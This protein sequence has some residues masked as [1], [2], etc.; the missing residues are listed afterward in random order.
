MLNNVKHAIRKKNLFFTV[1]DSVNNVKE[2]RYLL[3]KNI[4]SSFTQIS[5][6]KPC[7]IVYINY[8]A[9]FHAAITN[10]VASSSKSLKYQGTN[11]TSSNFV[12]NVKLINKKKQ[13][14]KNKNIIR[15]Q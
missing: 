12:I 5:S 6:P 3:M 14:N 2:L 13:S 8:C 1:K 9:N 11:F 10:A 7:I 15:F 4:I